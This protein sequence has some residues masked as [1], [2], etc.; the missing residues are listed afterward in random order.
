MLTWLGH[1][2]VVAGLLGWLAVC[3]LLAL[4]IVGL[5]GWD[6]LWAHRRER[7]YATQA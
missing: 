6:C 1:H 5:Y 2:P 7:R 3:L 4:V